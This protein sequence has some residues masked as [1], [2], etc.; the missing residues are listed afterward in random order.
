MKIK[1]E[2]RG[3]DGWEEVKKAVFVTVPMTEEASGWLRYELSDGTIGLAR[4]KD[5]RMIMPQS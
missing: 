2:V 4:S 1:F 3:S 5:W